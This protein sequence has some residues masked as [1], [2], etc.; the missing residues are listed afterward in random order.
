MFAQAAASDAAA[1]SGPGAVQNI[2]QD[3]LA[4]AAQAAAQ[5]D[6]LAADAFYNLGDRFAAAIMP[7]PWMPTRKPCAAHRTTWTPR[8]TFELAL[9][10]L[11]QK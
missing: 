3:T 1:N 7:A 11:Q 6:Q 8:S 4:Q 2:A 9:R 10:K 5:D